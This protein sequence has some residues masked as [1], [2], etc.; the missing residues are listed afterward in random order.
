[1]LSWASLMGRGEGFIERAEPFSTATEE[2]M[3]SYTAKLPALLA[4][5][6]V[7]SVNNLLDKLVDGNGQAVLRHGLR[8]RPPSLNVVAGARDPAASPPAHLA[9]PLAH[10]GESRAQPPDSAL[11]TPTAKEVG[12]SIAV[13]AEV[14]LPPEAFEQLKARD[15]LKGASESQLR[16]CSTSQKKEL[17]SKFSL[18]GSSYVRCTASPPPAPKGGASLSTDPHRP[19]GG[20]RASSNPDHL[21][22]QESDHACLRD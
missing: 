7:N 4:S 17:C 11:Q 10:P 18:D 21:P 8:Q 1:M 9:S 19:S 6:D 20:R 3:S 22:Q 16:K 13:S 5:T 12:K 15:L 14:G 2:E